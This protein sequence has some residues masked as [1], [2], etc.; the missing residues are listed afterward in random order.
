[1]PLWKQYLQ[2]WRTIA[3]L[4]LPDRY[5]RRT[6]DDAPETRSEKMF[7]ALPAVSG[8]LATALAAG[9]LL[10]KRRARSVR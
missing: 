9:Q 3:R 8:G 10:R 4:S 7:A 6:A 1:G 2:S 5:L